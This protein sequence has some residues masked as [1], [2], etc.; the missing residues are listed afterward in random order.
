MSTGTLVSR[1]ALVLALA[2]QASA[3]SSTQNV[4]VQHNLVSDIP[5]MADVTDPNLV[6]PWGMSFSATS[7]F[8]ISNAGKSN[9]TLYNGSGTITPVVVSIPAGASGPAKS[10]PTGQ[11]S[12]N[13]T[14]FLLANGNK[15]SFIFATEDG[16]ISA[17]NGGAAS[18]VMVD[19]S[20]KGAVY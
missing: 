1:I 2:G 4:Y 3:Q 20:A 16:T 7:P 13:T 10:S 12:N 14:V 18:T 17:W 19:N 15:A 8:W 6:D 5:G 11:V 9:S